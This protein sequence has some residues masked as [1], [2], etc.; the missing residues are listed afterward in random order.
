[1]LYMPAALFCCFFKTK[2]PDYD[3]Y[4]FSIQHV[5]VKVPL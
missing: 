1:M 4:L 2:A 5:H 3:S